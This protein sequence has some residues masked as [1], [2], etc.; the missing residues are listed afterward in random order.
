MDCWEICPTTEL[1]DASNYYTKQETDALLEAIE[2]SGTTY[3]QGSGITIQDGTIS[4]DPSVVATK[5]D[6][7]EQA[8]QLQDE[9]L[10]KASFDPY[11][12]AT[13]E[14][15]D[16]KQ[17]TLVSGT[18]IKTIN[19]ESLLGEG[20]IEIKTEGGGTTYTAGNGITIED[21]TISVDA[22]DLGIPIAQTTSTGT[23]NMYIYSSD[24]NYQGRSTLALSTVSAVT[25]GDTVE[26]RGRQWG[27]VV[28]SSRL[29][30]TID[31]SPYQKA[32]DA[33][34]VWCGTQ[35]EYDSLQS[36]DDNTLYL[37]HE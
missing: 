37:I 21:N 35:T 33:V 31:L 28:D 19:G 18:N 32:V 6:L 3:T 36:K 13:Q 34:K 7:L 25:D 20:N 17:P 5:E 2:A 29:F 27:D 1:A 30:G 8:E 22:S 4:I 26:I 16:S 12:A 14:A 9:F 10:S 15:I 24:A 23:K 11:S